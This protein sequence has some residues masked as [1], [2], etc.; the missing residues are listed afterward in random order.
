MQKRSLTD[1]VDDYTAVSH[2]G[3]GINSYSIN[4]SIVKAPLA[5][6]FQLSWGGVYGYPVMEYGSIATC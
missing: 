4:V 6:L 2:S 5:V 1:Q 3:H